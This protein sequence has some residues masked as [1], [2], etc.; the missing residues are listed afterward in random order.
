MKKISFI[1]LKKR[2][3]IIAL[4]IIILLT[5]A[6]FVPKEISTSSPKKA[7]TIALDA[8]HGGRDGGC[9]GKETGVMEKDLALSI[10]KKLQKQLSAYGFNVV[11]TRKDD[12]GLYSD[13]KNKK[14]QD[15]LARKKIVEQ[16]GSDC[17]IS[18][19]LNSFTSTQAIGSQAF[20]FEE[21]GSG[22]KLSDSLQDCLKTVLPNAKPESCK[23]DYYILK[24]CDVPSALVECGYLSNAQEEALLIT[25][26]Y[27]EKVAYA[28]FCGIV[29]FFNYSY[30]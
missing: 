8:G 20:F 29:K 6:I 30:C 18:I 3:I 7:I 24:C 23:G 12:R 28:I 26:K 27:Q 19:H 13:G 21:E 15:M 10:T 14:Q 22:K 4:L 1:T 11:L 17:L 16:S 5:C 25:D 9:V 2:T